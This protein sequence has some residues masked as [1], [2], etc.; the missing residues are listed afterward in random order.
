MISCIIQIQH[1]SV[2]HLSGVLFVGKNIHSRRDI[3]IPSS[4][5]V[6]LFSPR[7]YC[8][9]YITCNTRSIYRRSRIELLV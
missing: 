2:K 6:H 5:D 9:L 1:T 4:G 3:V 8:L 7:I